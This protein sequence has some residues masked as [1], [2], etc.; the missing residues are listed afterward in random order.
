M[1]YANGTKFWYVEGKLHRLDGPAMEYA[2]GTKFWYVEDKLHRLDC[3]AVEYANGDKSWYYQGDTFYVS[4]QKEF[5]QHLRLL[6]F[7]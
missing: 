2:N 7:L 5:E 6:A 4:S 3:P 1:E